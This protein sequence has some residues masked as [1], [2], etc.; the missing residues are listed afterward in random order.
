MKP[1]PIRTLADLRPNATVH[2]MVCEQQ[3][4]AAGAEKFHAHH[5]CRECA[6]K[7][8]AKPRQSP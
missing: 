1:A 7:L 6:A 5:V 3:R 2:C 4:P 8:R